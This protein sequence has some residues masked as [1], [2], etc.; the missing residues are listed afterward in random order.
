MLKTLRNTFGFG[1]HSPFAFEMITQVL[2][3]CHHYYGLEEL[4]RGRFIQKIPQGHRIER[5]VLN[6]AMKFRPGSI[7]LITLPNEELNEFIRYIDGNIGDKR[8]DIDLYVLVHAEPQYLQDLFI[9]QDGRSFIAVVIEKNKR[10]LNKNIDLVKSLL[11]AGM[12]FTNC[13]KM[14]VIATFPFLPRQDFKILY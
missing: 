12:T 11:Q 9:T 5:V 10:D 13:G 1:V 7:K 6:I 3:S 14:C 2:R 8:T 4:K